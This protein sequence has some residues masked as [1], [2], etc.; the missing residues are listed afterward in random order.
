MKEDFPDIIENQ[1]KIS[2]SRIKEVS[3]NNEKLDDKNFPVSGSFSKNKVSTTILI[4][5]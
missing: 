2:D 4:P 1:K 3:T 5:R